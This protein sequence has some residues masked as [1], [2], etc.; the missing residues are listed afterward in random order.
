MSSLFSLNLINFNAAIDHEAL[1]ELLINVMLLS[2]PLG[3]QQAA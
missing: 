3:A 2:T 1:E